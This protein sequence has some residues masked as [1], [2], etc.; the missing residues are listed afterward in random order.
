MG[1][2]K[3]WTAERRAKQAEA[4]RR[5]RPWD[6]STGPRTAEGKVISSRNACLDD[7]HL[8]REGRYHEEHLTLRGLMGWGRLS[9]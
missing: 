2:S 5:W 7:A 6:Q 4:I 1:T 8:E 3:S 9:G